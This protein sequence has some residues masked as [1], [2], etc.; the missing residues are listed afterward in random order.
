MFQD[1]L[2]GLGFYLSNRVTVTVT[3]G[4]RPFHSARISTS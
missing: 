2:E 3:D 1:L 4:E